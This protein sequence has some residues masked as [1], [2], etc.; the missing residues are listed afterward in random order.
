MCLENLAI[1]SEE[2]TSLKLT[3]LNEIITG[4]LFA[5]RKDI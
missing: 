4:A 5:T 2:K 3:Y 1:K